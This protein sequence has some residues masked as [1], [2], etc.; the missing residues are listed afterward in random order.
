MSILPWSLLL[1]S[2]LWTTN[3]VTII[4]GAWWTSSVPREDLLKLLR[5]S[6]LRTLSGPLLGGGSAMLLLIPSREVLL[7]WLPCRRFLS[8]IPHASS[9]SGVAFNLFWKKWNCAMSTPRPNASWIVWL[10][11]GR[12]TQG[13]WTLLRHILC[14]W[15]IHMPSGL[16]KTFVGLLT[17]L[18]TSKK[19]DAKLWAS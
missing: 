15:I 4:I 16:K 19:R 7:C 10:A 6:L 9:F 1:R 12:G 2:I 13:L 17:M 18:L 5:A 3:L 8:I 11:L 14:I